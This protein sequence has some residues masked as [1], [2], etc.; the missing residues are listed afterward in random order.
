MTGMS[1]HENVLTSTERCKSEQ[2]RTASGSTRTNLS[3]LSNCPGS[4][5][6]RERTGPSFFLISSGDRVSIVQYCSLNTDCRLI[7]V[8]L[9]VSLSRITSDDEWK[10]SRSRIK[11][12]LYGR[13]EM[14]SWKNDEGV[15]KL[16]SDL[17]SATTWFRVW[18]ALFAPLVPDL[19]HSS[20][21]SFGSDLLFE[22]VKRRFVRGPRVRN[23]LSESLGKQMRRICTLV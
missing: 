12:C 6:I 2:E 20:L 4:D 23:I 10:S 5:N 16:W 1:C 8:N 11:D 3:N 13:L 22:N 17:E 14:T 9:W 15:A 18:S 19:K 21:H 7:S